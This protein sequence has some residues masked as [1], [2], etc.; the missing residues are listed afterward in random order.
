MFGSAAAS[1]I[2]LAHQFSRFASDTNMTKKPLSGLIAVRVKAK[3]WALLF[4]VGEVSVV[5]AGESRVVTR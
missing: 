5:V 2:A 1:V 4:A 3:L